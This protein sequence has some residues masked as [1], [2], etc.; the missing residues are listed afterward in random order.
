V[1]RLFPPPG[2]TLPAD[3]VY[4]DLAWPAPGPERP[5]VAINMVCTVDGKAAVARR[6]MGIG[7]ATDRLLM[8]QLR[9]W[10]DAVMTGAGTLRA[11]EFL[12]TVEAAHA[13]RRR[14]RGLA[15]QPVGV[16]VS[17]SGALPR[18]RR[19]FH[20]ERFARVLLTTARGAAALDPALAARLDVL[21]LGGEEVDLAA[22]LR[23]LRQERG[24][25]W[26]LCEGGP[27][28]NH[29]LLAAD[30]V[31]ELFLTLAPKVVGGPGPTIVEGPPL[32]ARPP[33]QLL[34]VHAAGAELYL[35]YRLVRA[36]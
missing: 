1:L 23:R 7:S 19:Y 29:A 11:E 6:A 31:D 8:R 16:L 22:A 3:A 15:P 34:A 30:L 9:C 33:L 4:D 14:A 25:R 17:R 26:L 32:P 12:P 21:V 5:F 35:R 2:G 27:T 24:I 28:L 20:D 10:V 36:D 18:A 13:A